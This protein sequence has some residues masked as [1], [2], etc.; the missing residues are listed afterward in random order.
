MIQKGAENF[1][2]PIARNDGT[3]LIRISVL[4]GANASAEGED[5]DEG[6]EESAGERVLDLADSFR[7]Q[8]MEGV[9][10][11]AYQGELKSRPGTLD[12]SGMLL[13]D[14]FRIHEGLS[15]EDEG[16]GKTR[17]RS[18]GVPDW[19]TSGSEEDPR[20]LGQLRC[21]QGRVNGRELDVHLG[22][23]P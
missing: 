4:E 23:L 6:G 19:S 13:T 22:R 15:R 18:Q 10:K 14:A 20:Q 5:A 2:Q 12:R 8:K 16:A 1:G 9:S 17:G 11:K 21:V 3:Q 7:W